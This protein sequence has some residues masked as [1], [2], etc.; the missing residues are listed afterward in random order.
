MIGSPRKS[1]VSSGL[2]AL[3]MLGGCE[4]ST[5][6]W[7]DLYL[8]AAE[9]LGPEA[10]GDRQ[11]VVSPVPGRPNGLHGPGG[12][13]V[14]RHR[15]LCSG[16]Q[17]PGSQASRK[18]LLVLRMDTPNRSTGETFIQTSRDY[19][20]AEYYPKIR[21]ALEGLGEE[22]IWRRPNQAS[23]SMGNLIL[24]LA[25]N[26][27]QWVVAG[28]GGAR[29]IRDRDAE[30]LASGGMSGEDLLQHLGDTLEDVDRVLSDLRVEALDERRTIQ[31][32][33]VSILEAL[34]HVVEHFSM[35]TGQ[36]IYLAKEITGRDLDFYRV[37]ED[38]VETNW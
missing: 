8:L 11:K 19:L 18:P 13:L 4:G 9:A 15:I 20:L 14:D 30:F 21:R 35:H 37:K 27:R 29:D 24:H 1:A 23:N 12:H 16:M 2:L 6:P 28:I 26:A 34:Y 22:E 36:I 7:E 5:S 38:G 10:H 25:G 33:S 32:F 17:G 31:G 3:A